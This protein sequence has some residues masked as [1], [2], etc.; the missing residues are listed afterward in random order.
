MVDVQGL[1]MLIS[2]GFGKKEFG[3]KQDKE[4]DNKRRA[5]GC[6]PTLRIKT[7]RKGTPVQMPVI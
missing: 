1:E 3:Q 5:I 4:I 2:R 7:K 6:G